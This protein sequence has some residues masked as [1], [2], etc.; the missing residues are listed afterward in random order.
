MTNIIRP[1]CFSTANND[2]AN[3]MSDFK[4]S[5]CESCVF[6]LFSLKAQEIDVPLASMGRLSAESELAYVFPEGKHRSVLRG[7]VC[8]TSHLV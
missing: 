6:A 7:Q 3:N 2:C 1:I 5:V 8:F 4:V